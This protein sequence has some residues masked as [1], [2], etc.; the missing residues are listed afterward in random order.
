MS[1]YYPNNGYYYPNNGYV[2]NQITAKAALDTNGDGYV[3]RGN[4]HF[5]SFLQDT[6][7]LIELNIFI[8]KL[9]DFY[10]AAAMRNGGYVTANDVYSTER[11]FNRFDY[12]HSGT[13]DG[14]EASNVYNYSQY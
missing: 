14:R 8:S 1:Y 13:L 7:L 10:Q 3:T 5:I 11:V 9:G 6:S 2:N 12:N 4:V